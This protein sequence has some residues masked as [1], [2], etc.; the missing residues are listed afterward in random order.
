MQKKGFLS[1]TTPSDS[2]QSENT[3]VGAENGPGMT[4]LLN[5]DL[6]AI[7]KTGQ[8]FL[9]QTDLSTIHDVLDVACGT[10]EWVIK[11]A[12]LYPHMQVMGI[13]SNTRLIDN[14]RAQ[15]QAAGAQNTR[16][17]QMHPFQPF[18]FPDDSFDL[19]N[20]RFVANFVSRETWP[21]LLQECFRITRRGGTV[22]LAES[23]LP[24]SNSRAFENFTGMIARALFLTRQSFS[25]DGV[26]LSITPM[27]S[28][29]LQ[30]AGYVE[31][32]QTTSAVNFSTGM[33][34]HADVSEDLAQTY[35]LMQPFLV[36][37]GA[38]TQ[39]EVSQAY[40]QMLAD[41]QAEDFS[42]VGFYLVVWGKKP[43]TNTGD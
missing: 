28:Q 32:Q 24:I 10:G 1:M 31:I 22:R 13:D 3:R 43:R 14:A 11:T 38:A 20:V 23:D 25:P 29:L 8:V 41:M 19:I 5:L 12:L 40:Q 21:A 18:D 34:A 6:P 26:S 33:D 7:K 27:L 36:S 9:E 15:A 30:Q 2:H 4:R 35:Q 37:T 39:A 17:T 16:F 42:A